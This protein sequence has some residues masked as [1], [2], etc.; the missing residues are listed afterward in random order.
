MCPRGVGSSTLQKTTTGLVFTSCTRLSTMPNLSKKR[1]PRANEPQIGPSSCTSTN[2]LQIRNL[3][4]F[5]SEEAA[6][7]QCDKDALRHRKG[8]SRRFSTSKIVLGRYRCTDQTLRGV[9]PSNRAAIPFT[10]SSQECKDVEDKL[11]D[12]IPWLTKLKENI[13]TPHA[14]EDGDDAQRRGHL[15]RFVSHTHHLT[16]LN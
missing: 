10:R 4:D 7:H 15:T 3:T 2:Q 1:R 14:D 12:L 6:G 11:G 13:T 5:H 16:D 9:S 8:V